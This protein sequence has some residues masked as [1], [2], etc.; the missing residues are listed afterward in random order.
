MAN[1]QKKPIPVRL[2]PITIEEIDK[3][4]EKEQENRS[5]YLRKVIENHVILKKM[6][7]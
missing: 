6:G 7:M 4:A 3:L 5:E 1:N 2:K